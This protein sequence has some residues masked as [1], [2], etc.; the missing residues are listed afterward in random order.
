MLLRHVVSGTIFAA[1]ITNGAEHFTAGGNTTQD[2]ITFLVSDFITYIVEEPH[3][4]SP[5]LVGGTELFLL[6]AALEILRQDDLKKMINIRTH[7]RRNG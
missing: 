3:R 6:H 5:L 7:T 1:G 4:R 2:E